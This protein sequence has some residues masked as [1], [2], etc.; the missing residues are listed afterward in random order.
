[1]TRGVVALAGGVGG[2][3]LALG[4][5][6]IQPVGKLT[7]VVNT[8]DDEEFFGLHVSPDVDTV[9]YTLAGVSNPHTGWGILDDSYRILDRLKSL[10][11]DSWFNLGD[12][13]FA[14]HIMRTDMLKKGW[15]LSQVTRALSDALGIEHRIVP[16]TDDRV[17]TVLSTD[18]GEL[19]MQTYFVKNQCAPVVESIKFEGAEDSVPSPGFAD[20]LEFSECLLFCPSNPFVSLAPILSIPGVKASIEGFGG[21]R[22]A[23]S[24]IVNGTAIKGPAAKMLLELGHD[25]SC[26]G[27]AKQYVGLCDIFVM[28]NLDESL[29]HEVEQLGMRVEMTNTIMNTE[30]DKERLAQFVC[31]II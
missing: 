14:T 16:M 20:A 4:M 15:T 3:K 7:V 24:P 18:V 28:D 10:G 9:M 23:V 26:V 11:V 17:R 29:C 21:T 25:V 12:L 31:D 13:D 30:A 27:V 19:P 6:I 22:I 1:M 5:S 8:G 2:A